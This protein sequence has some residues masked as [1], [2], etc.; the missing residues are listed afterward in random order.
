MQIGDSF[1]KVLAFEGFE[2]CQIEGIHVLLDE[3]C[4]DEPKL[5]LAFDSDLGWNPL[6]LPNVYWRIP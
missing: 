6:F 1:M 4:L 3:H 5:Q 2:M